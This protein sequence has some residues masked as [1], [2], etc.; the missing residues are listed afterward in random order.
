MRGSLGMEKNQKEYAYSG[1]KFPLRAKGSD[2]LKRFGIISDHIG[3]L[4]DVLVSTWGT[5]VM[6]FVVVLLGVFVVFIIGSKYTEILLQNIPALVIF[7]LS[8]IGIALQVFF[9]NPSQGMQ[10]KVSTHFLRRRFDRFG[11]TIAPEKLRPFRFAKNVDTK[12]VLVRDTADGITY[13]ALYSVTGVYSPVSF[14]NELERYANLDANVLA[15]LERDT[16]LTTAVG[17]TRVEATKLELPDNA[18]QAM[19][20]ERNRRYQKSI[21]DSNNKKIVTTMVLS[22]PSLEILQKRMN[23]L[24]IQ[25]RNGLVVGYYR[26]SGAELKKAIKEIYM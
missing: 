9:V 22:A 14:D 12:D 3:A 19:I 15:N 4:G 2:M 8:I 20:I 1:N 17:I 5:I 11:R 24:E 25:F 13:L 7:M 18:T 23:S 21:R 26:L 6:S 16:T 10:F